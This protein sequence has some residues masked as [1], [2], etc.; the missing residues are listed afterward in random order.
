MSEIIRIGIDLGGTK[1]EGVAIDKNGTILQR[2]RI[3]TPKGNY[4]KTVT[5][6]GDLVL[7]LERDTGYKGSVG[8]GIPGA[9]SK[10]TGKIKGANSTWLIGEALDKDISN[11]LNRPVR[12]ANDA[13]CFALSEAIDG[14]GTGAESVFGVILGTGVGGGLIL[15]GRPI[16]GLN[17]IAGEWGHNPLPAPID[18]DLPL[19]K[20][21]CRR[22]GCIET[23]ISGPALERIFESKTHTRKTATDISDLADQGDLQAEEIMAQYED[24]LARSLGSLINIFDPD[25]IILGGG[26]SKITRL[27]KNVPNIWDQ[28]IFSDHVDTK[29]MPPSH[30]DSSGVRGAAWLWGEGEYSALTMKEISK[31]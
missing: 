16:N 11:Y 12:L 15:N 19:Q 25:I 1:I 8:I 2:T 30:G 9:F 6:I 29:L 10:H 3:D 26:L 17:G 27:Y 18:A 7:K 31:S 13:N 4:P 14:N 22:K 23:F 28:Y 20:C 5:A 21:Y 24:R